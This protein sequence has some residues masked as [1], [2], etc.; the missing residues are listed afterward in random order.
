MAIDRNIDPTIINR[1]A[2]FVATLTYKD[3]PV[4]VVDCTKRF[5]ADTCAVSLA[6]RVSPSTNGI[7]ESAKLWN[8]NNT[9]PARVFGDPDVKLTPANAAFVNGYKAHC[10]EWDALHEEAISIGF[11]TPVGALLAECEVRE[12]SGEELITALAAAVEFFTILGLS[13]GSTATFF[14]PSAGGT[15]SAALAIA[16]VRKYSVEMTK[17]T[18]G[19]AYSLAGGTMQAHWEGVATLA[20]QVGAGSRS[21]IYAADMAGAGI[22]APV[23]I[24]TGKF[25]FYSIFE[26]AGNFAE[27]SKDLGNKWRIPET[28]YKPFPCGRATHGVLTVLKTLKEANNL[29]PD[30]IKFIK[31]TAPPLISVLVDRPIKEEMSPGYAR[32]C[33]PFIL[34]MYA[35][36]GDIDPSAFSDPVRPTKRGLDLASKLEICVAENAPTNTLAPIDVQ[37][38]MNDG[39]RYEQ[40]CK[41]PWGAPGNPFTEA[42]LVKKIEKCLMHDGKTQ[43]SA[44]QFVSAFFE[45][46]KYSSVHSLI[47]EIYN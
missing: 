2:S 32:L 17:N 31:V 33:L 40:H 39:Q 12:I 1:I 37:I 16:R 28:S 21:A 9:G 34:S 11:C 47:D 4:E 42:D 7:I 36:H 19:L 30:V 27:L 35:Y 46:E 45:I 5:L 24:F 25:G 18:L 20:M 23:D 10:L 6:G 26:S 14:R 8:E 3:I 15:L 29:D 22:A 38:T 13:S 41:N 43:I 44:Q